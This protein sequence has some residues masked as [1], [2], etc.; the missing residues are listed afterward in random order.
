MICLCTSKYKYIYYILQK[1]TDKN[2]RKKKKKNVKDA[3]LG[4]GNYGRLPRGTDCSFDIT[5]TTQEPTKARQVTTLDG[6][7]SWS[8]T[9]C[10]GARPREKELPPSSCSVQSAVHCK[11][12]GKGQWWQDRLSLFQPPRCTPAPWQ[13]ASENSTFLVAAPSPP[14]GLQMPHEV[15]PWY[16]AGEGEF[17]PFV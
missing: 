3:L 1:H 8:P 11:A 17:I 15:T 7:Q 10:A 6:A 14:A 5:P 16:M 2:W 12:K 9:C 13:K 4:P